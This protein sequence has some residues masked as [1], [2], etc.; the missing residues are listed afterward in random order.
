MKNTHRLLNTETKILS[1]T[2]GIVEYIASDQSLDSDGHIVSASGWVLDRFAKNAPFVDSHNYESLDRLVGAVQATRV[3]GKSLIA[4]VKWAVDVPANT[5]A[6]L[7][8]AMTRAGYLKAV[9]VGFLPIKYASRFS[10]EPHEWVA[11]LAAVGQPKDSPAR[12]VF[13]QQRLIELSSCIVGA[14]PA[15]VAKAYKSGALTDEQ[16]NHFAEYQHE[17]KSTGAFG[18]APAPEQSMPPQSW[19]QRFEAACKR[20]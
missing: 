15:A 10:S 5:L 18:E 7:G 13:L 20:L 3:E 16:L 12:L 9:S 8:W 11:A 4:T 17:N 14:N 6:A 1:E 2:E 19:F